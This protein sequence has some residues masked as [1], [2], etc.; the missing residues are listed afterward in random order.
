NI[1]AEPI[2]TKFKGERILHTR[3][4]PVCDANG[5]PQYLLGI[6]EDITERV[7]AEQML[8]ELADV[9]RY[10]RDAVV[11]WRPNG[12]VVSWNPGAERLYGVS[13][14]NAMGKAFARFVPETDVDDLRALERRVLAG[15]DV[16]VREVTR[17]RADGREIE[18]EESL[19]AVLDAEGL[20]QR[21][22]SIARDM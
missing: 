11:T 15:D 21:I 7:R 20:P 5:E 12:V 10:L 22:A 8:R 2:E 9:V 1:P 6:S 3:K 16:G 17:L 14:E 18:V 19:F 13:A 4:I